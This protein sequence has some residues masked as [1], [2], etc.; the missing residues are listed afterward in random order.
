MAIATAVATGGNENYQ[1]SHL[2]FPISSFSPGITTEPKV[3]PGL[4]NEP[5]VTSDT[6]SCIIP[7]SRAGNLIVIRAKVDSM[8]GNFILDTGAPKLILNMTYFRKYLFSA[9][10]IESG[11][12]T[13]SVAASTVTIP[14]L[15][16]GP[17]KYYQVETDLVNLGN[18][19]SSKGIKILGLLGMQL[20][21]KFE[22]II[23]YEKNLIHLHLVGK[24]ET[25]T[26]KSELLNDTAA[27]HTMRIKIWDNK[28]L[29]SGEIAGKKLNFIIDTGAESN[30][31][32]SLLPGKV[33]QEINITSRVLLAGAGD[34]KVE[35]L[36]GDMKN[37]KLGNLQINSVPVLVTNL[38]KMCLAYEQ[39]LD[40]MLGFDFLSLHKIGF[41]FVTGKMYIWK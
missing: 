11:G 29:T 14:G 4:N 19:E 25:S 27:Y 33:F 12:I 35:A 16:F 7:F 26:Y 20:F 22:M 17:V 28:L 30:V 40:G 21:K 36:Y 1:L 37:M 9:V 5:V 39:C 2:I 32:D 15:S 41:I 8:E 3:L 6:P 31:L 24:K 38:E 23:D 18:I 13:G 10:N 34:Q